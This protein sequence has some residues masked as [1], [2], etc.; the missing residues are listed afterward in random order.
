MTMSRWCTLAL[1][2]VVL[3]APNPGRA[4][5]PTQYDPHVNPAGWSAAPYDHGYGK[6]KPA[7]Y[8]PVGPLPAGPGRTIYEQLPDDTG[9]L[10]EDSPLERALK[11][12]FRHAYFRV[13]YL[14]WSI[15]D[16]GNNILGSS[17]RMLNARQLGPNDPSDPAY[18]SQIDPTI[19]LV[20][21]FTSPLAQQYVYQPFT[22]P[23][24]P[25]Q[26]SNPITDNNTL[27]SVVA[28]SMRDVNI[29]QNNGLRLTFGLPTNRA[30]T[31]EGSIFSLQSSTSQIRRRQYGRFD[32]SYDSDGDFVFGNGDPNET[33]IGTGIGEFDRNGNGLVDD[34][35][36]DW[37]AIATPILIDMSLPI[38][39]KVTNLSSVTGFPL[40]WPGINNPLGR[41]DNF[42]IVWAV[43]NP[44]PVDRLVNP[45][46]NT[47]NASIKTSVWGTEA[48]WISNAFGVDHGSPLSVKPMFGFRYA[49]FAEDLYQR[50]AY[51]FVT[52]NPNNNQPVDN[53]INRRIDAG[54][55]NNL[56][57]PQ[58]GLRA[59]L[60]SKYV[61]LG[62]QP[63]VML[64]LNTYRANL[65]TENVLRPGSAIQGTPTSEAEFLGLGDV[66]QTLSDRTTTFGVLGDL[67]VYSRVRLTSCLHAFV[68]Y[69]LMWAGQITRPG[70][71]IVYN[72]RTVTIDPDLDPNDTDTATRLDSDF[73]LDVKYSGAL[74]QG[75]T[76]GAELR[77]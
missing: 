17:T 24:T 33:F 50:G 18:P 30:G 32:N 26:V 40:V 20:A 61:T 66:N 45:W 53:T 36:N 39:G 8:G 21:P 62:V 47:Y 67:E 1:L 6:H 41:G 74:I 65:E 3:G 31:F 35:V 63:K 46:V 64:G 54:T 49:Y 28:P 77:Y 38:P 55:I 2:L 27:I 76:V 44:D 10:Y 37:E 29:N 57:G 48:N 75:L 11:E 52:I 43:R 71:N 12:T 51:T 4:Q 60:A 42:R 59:E 72:A 15:E 25:F 56:Y 58:L 5:P 7:A 22:D 69:N 16:P 68:G 9:W 13:D 34:V 70:D 73:K 19:P 23:L 14:L